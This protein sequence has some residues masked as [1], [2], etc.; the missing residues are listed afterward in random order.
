MHQQQGAKVTKFP[1]SQR[2]SILDKEV[3]S[4]FRKVLRWPALPPCWLYL[5][6]PIAAPLLPHSTTSQWADAQRTTAPPFRLRMKVRDGALW[7]YN[8]RHAGIQQQQQHTTTINTL[9]VH[10]V[11]QEIKSL[12][13]TQWL[14]DTVI[15]KLTHGAQGLVFGDATAPYASATA[16]DAATRANARPAVMRWREGGGGGGG[17]GD[18]VVEKAVLLAH[19]QK[20]TK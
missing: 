8:A 17:G 2:L 9:R 15:P 3:V 10:T 14:M 13:R 4:P 1:W 7:M 5:T 16:Q 20:Y 11:L 19:L 12:K 18:E 6:S